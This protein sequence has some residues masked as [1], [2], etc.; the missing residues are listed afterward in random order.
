[1]FVGMDGCNLCTK[2]SEVFWGGSGRGGLLQLLLLHG[3]VGS[4]C[5][6]VHW[7]L[8]MSARSGR[9][10]NSGVSGAPTCKS[11]SLGHLMEQLE[12]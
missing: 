10:G 1:M 6:T 7:A 12:V 8:S 4:S 11:W 3:T 5:S 9:P 2:H